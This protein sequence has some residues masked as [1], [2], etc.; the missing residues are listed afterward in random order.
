MEDLDESEG[1]LLQT[2]PRDI[3]VFSVLD[4][5]LLGSVL[6]GEFSPRAD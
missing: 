4:G 1:L 2:S 6:Q 3:C 5:G